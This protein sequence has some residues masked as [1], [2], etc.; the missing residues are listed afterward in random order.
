MRL[1]SAVVPG[2]L[3]P[4]LCGDVDTFGVVYAGPRCEGCVECEDLEEIKLTLR[5]ALPFKPCFIENH[6]HQ[7][8]LCGGCGNS[9]YRKGQHWYCPELVYKSGDHVSTIGTKMQIEVDIPDEALV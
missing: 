4:E 7:M 8:A 6:N 9:G 5:A 2:N 1:T 3:C